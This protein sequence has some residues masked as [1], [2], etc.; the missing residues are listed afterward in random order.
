M[1]WAWDVTTCDHG[2]NLTEDCGHCLWLELL[3]MNQEM[4]RQFAEL[5]TSEGDESPEEEELWICDECGAIFPAHSEA[6]WSHCCQ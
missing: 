2:V 1:T 3:E 4:T 6:V 5:Q